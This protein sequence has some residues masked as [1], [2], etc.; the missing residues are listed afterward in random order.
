MR[1]REICPVTFISLAVHLIALS[2]F[3]VSFLYSGSRAR[4]SGYPYVFFG[5]G[6][7]EHYD[8]DGTAP[9]GG[10]AVRFPAAKLKFRV[11]CPSGPAGNRPRFFSDRN[12]LLSAAPSMAADKVSA[13]IPS[14]AAVFRRTE[15]KPLSMYPL[16]PAY[17]PLYFKDREKAHIELLF[18]IAPSAGGRAEYIEVKRKTSCGNLEADLIALR[19]VAYY[20]FLQRRYFQGGRWHNVEVDFS[21][22]HVER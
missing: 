1:F 22:S 5:A 16:L 13:V 12:P 9:A 21:P 20:L 4:Q 15:N 8:L 19:Q 7:L 2:L 10:P 6:L 17:F 11:P 14:D 18:R 3:S